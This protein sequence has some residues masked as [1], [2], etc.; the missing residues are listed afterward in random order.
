LLLQRNFF[1]IGLRHWTSA[2]KL[3]FLRSS[4]FHRQPICTVYWLR[5]Y[6]TCE[7]TVFEW[8]IQ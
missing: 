4:A 1:P 6:Y 2:T 7:T 8:K 3:R 5:S